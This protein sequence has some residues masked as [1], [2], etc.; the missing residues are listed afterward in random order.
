MHIN[1]RLKYWAIRAIAILVGLYIAFV[2]WLGLANHETY[3]NNADV[4]VILG[5]KSYVQGRVNACLVQRVQKGVDLYRSGVVKT[6]IVSG[7]VD[8]EDGAIESQIMKQIAVAQGVPKQDII[9]EN[10]ASSTWENIQFAQNI[11]DEK[12]LGNRVIVVSESFH[13]ARAQAVANKQSLDWTVASSGWCRSQ[14]WGPFRTLLRE[15]FAWA[16]YVLHD[17]IR[18]W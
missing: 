6:L 8:R 4:A 10:R 11:V 14:T 18:V 16:D 17:Q 1:P 7:G 9:E 13:I 2:A 5:A 3:K 15:P 12:Q